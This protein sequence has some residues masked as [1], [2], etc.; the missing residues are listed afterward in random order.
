M[1]GQKGCDCA[2]PDYVYILVEGL[3]KYLVSYLCGMI[4]GKSSRMPWMKFSNLKE[5]C[6]EHLWAQSCY[7]GSVG[8]G[9]DV[10]EKYISAH[11]SYGHN[12]R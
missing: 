9:W 11:N 10:V 6:G 7:H 2:N 4:K 5:W 8:N 12:R 1:W 3:P